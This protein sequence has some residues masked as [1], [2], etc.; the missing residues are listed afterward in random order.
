MLLI[1]VQAALLDAG[2][3]ASLGQL[4]A[5]LVPAAAD[6]A[7]AAEAGAL[8]TMALEIITVLCN[9]DVCLDPSLSSQQ[10]A[11]DECVGTSEVC[12]LHGTLTFG[13]LSCTLKQWDCSMF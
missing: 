2:C 11:T 6:P 10:R 8:T 12:C 4:L 7:K 9:I 1:G 3:A 13:P 5:R